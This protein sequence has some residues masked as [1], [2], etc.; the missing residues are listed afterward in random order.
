MEVGQAWLS[1]PRQLAEGVV[2][3]PWLP[4]VWR[5]VGGRVDL[6]LWAPTLPAE[7]PCCFSACIE[8]SLA[9]GPSRAC[10]WGFN[11][12]VCRSSQ[13]DALVLFPFR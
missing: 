10:A 11:A 8:A 9:W 12:Q 4:W 13:R 5:G 3:S 2:M 1:K 6:T 7:L